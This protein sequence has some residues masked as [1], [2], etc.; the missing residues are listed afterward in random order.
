MK[1]SGWW[2]IGLCVL[3]LLLLGG[4]VAVVSTSRGFRNKNPGNLRPLSG[5]KV[6]SG[7]VGIDYQ[8]STAGY[9]IF[10][11]FE[12]GIRAMA[13]D[14]KVKA[15]RGLN[16]IAKILPVYAPSADNNNVQAYIESVESYSGVDRD[17][18]LTAAELLP[19][20]MAMARH[21]LGAASFALVPEKDFVAGVA[22]A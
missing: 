12:N 6:W 15:A 19:V 1:F 18:V 13:R 4:G 14:L 22:R 2:L 3:A 11:S 10:D 21:E 5:G 16:T 8:G 20:V 9:I 7:Q 17:T